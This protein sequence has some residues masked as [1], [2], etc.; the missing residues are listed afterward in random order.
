MAR[1][2]VTTS[3]G[4]IHCTR[5]GAGTPL[6]L[7]A[8][9]GRSARM[10]SALLPKLADSFDVIAFDTPGFGNSDPLPEGATIEQIARAFIEALDGLGIERTAIYGLHTGHKI[11]TAM[12]NQAPRRITK[13][14]LAGQSHSLVPDQETRNAGIRQSVSAYVNFGGRGT[15]KD[16]AR[17]QATAAQAGAL[18]QLAGSSPDSHP[19]F[20]GH[21]L[22][23]AL[24]KIQS[25]GIA[26][27]YLANFHYDLQRG[28]RELGV[29]TL[30]L[31][32]ATDQ[33]TKHIGLQGEKI[34]QLIR[35]STL[36]TL[37][38]PDGR[39]LTLENRPD[40]LAHIIKSFLH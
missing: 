5:A 23:H 22:D 14:I 11:A 17:A 32:I 31:E 38:V 16:A 29:P 8:A 25:E 39:G 21:V 30:V 33:E 40:D 10:F 27:L 37:H 28:L 3:L 24:D 18:L 35:G 13:L 34:A 4:Q 9:A 2:Y 26:D 1:H 7:L 12:A 15:G 20:G 19:V 36:L 6:V